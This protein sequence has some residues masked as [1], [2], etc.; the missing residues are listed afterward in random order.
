M[1]MSGLHRRVYVMTCMNYVVSLTNIVSFLVG[2]C[3]VVP[4]C[5]HDC[6]SQ[7]VSS[8]TVDIPLYGQ[9]YMFCL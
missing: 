7:G 9:S 1:C 8:L 5:D 3:Y 2:I 4:A 6:L